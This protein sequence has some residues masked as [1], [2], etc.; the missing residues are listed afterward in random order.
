MQRSGSDLIFSWKDGNSFSTLHTVSLPAGTTF[1]VG[2]VF[3][4]TEM[5]QSL[6]ASFD[7]AMLVE[8]STDFTTWMETN[9]FSDANAEYGDTGLG[10]LMAYALGRDLSDIVEPT[11][12]ANGDSVSFTHRQR[13]PVSNLDYS[14]ESST[15]LIDW[16]PAG[17][18]APNGAPTLNPDGTYTVNLLSNLT[19][20]EQPKIFYRLVVRLPQ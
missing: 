9:G 1:S 11:F 2:G 7:Y 16:A 8:Q 13:I 4:S 18:L 14:V 5:T 3:A 12:N 10:N 6:E 20:V 17:D 19:P 15:N